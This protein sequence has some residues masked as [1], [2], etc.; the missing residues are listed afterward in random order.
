MK[1]TTSG[2]RHRPT[3]AFDPARRHALRWAAAAAA[4]PALI[5]ALAACRRRR[6]KAQPVP[7]GAT[8]L[9]LGDSLTQGVGASAEQAFPPLLAQATGW[10]VVNAGVSG[11]TSAQ[12]LARLPELLQQ[13]R[14]QLVIVGIGGNDFLRRQ[15]TSQ[16]KQNI[17]RIVQACLDANAQVLLVAI[18]GLGL[19]ATAGL[20]SDHAMY[21]EIA[22]EL[23]V[24]LLADAWAQVLSEP[25][26]RSDQIHAN[27]QGYAVFADK[28]LAGL[29]AHGL[30][31]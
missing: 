11:D 30:L 29:R 1:H 9:A 10:Q 26:L 3:T 7:A 17:T 19:L 15:S 2:P 5:A 8:V 18:P 27:A 31:R 28:L 21:E 14:P 16:T 6:A 12:A 20:L 22:D 4:A 25:Q 13:H 24:P 23:G